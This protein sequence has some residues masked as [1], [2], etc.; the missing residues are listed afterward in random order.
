MSRPSRAA[1]NAHPLI[2]RLSGEVVWLLLEERGVPDAEI[3]AFMERWE[4]PTFSSLRALE[5]LLAPG[6]QGGLRILIRGAGNT[7]ACPRCAALDGL[8]VPAG[9][10]SLVALCP[11]YAVNCPARAEFLE[12]G[13]PTLERALAPHDPG[14]ASPHGELLCPQPPP[15][16]DWPAT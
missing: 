16:V 6:A 8:I 11:P 4:T 9:H 14:P 5:R 2:R 15:G 12:P 1:F 13:D 3:Q 7:A 10:P